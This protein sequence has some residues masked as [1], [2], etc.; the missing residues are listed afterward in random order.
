MEFVSKR[1]GECECVGER[2]RPSVVGK[3]VRVLGSKAR[4][5]LH[6]LVLPTPRT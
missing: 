2:V 1:V 5:K 3:S 6:V 4:Q